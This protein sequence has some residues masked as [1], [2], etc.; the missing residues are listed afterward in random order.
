[1]EKEVKGFRNRI[2]TLVYIIYGIFSVIEWSQISTIY[3]N[4]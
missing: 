4:Y 3:N 1:M 2:F